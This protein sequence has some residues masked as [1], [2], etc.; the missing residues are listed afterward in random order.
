MFQGERCSIN[1]W[2]AIFIFID[3]S[4]L[5]S[6]ETTSFGEKII[7]DQGYEF[8]N[9]SDDEEE[10]EQ[11]QKSSSAE[12]FIS[13]ATQSSQLVDKTGS[14]GTICINCI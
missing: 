8:L 5:P 2:G 13:S 12:R 4:R 9:G 3:F 6:M 1:K 14:Q 11:Q 7:G 10:E